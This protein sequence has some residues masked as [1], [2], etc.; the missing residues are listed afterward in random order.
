MIPPTTRNLL[1]ADFPGLSRQ[2]HLRLVEE[3]EISQFALR[4]QVVG[5]LEGLQHAYI[6]CMKEQFSKLLRA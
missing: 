4:R 1:V 2:L 3:L 5:A 6:A